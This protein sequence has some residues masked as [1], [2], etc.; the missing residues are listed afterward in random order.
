M[1]IKT[2]VGWA[3]ARHDHR[4]PMADKTI[5][6]PSAVPHLA[7]SDVDALEADDRTAKRVHHSKSKTDFQG[8]LP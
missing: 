1:T 5:P 8:G 4:N 6:E 3:F 2:K 7:G